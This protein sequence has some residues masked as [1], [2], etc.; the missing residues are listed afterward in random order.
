MC[1]FVSLIYFIL[2]NIFIFQCQFSVIHK[3]C[4]L[5]FILTLHFTEECMPKE[6]LPNALW[7]VLAK[8]VFNL[9]YPWALGVAQQLKYVKNIFNLNLSCLLKGGHKITF[10]VRWNRQLKLINVHIQKEE[11]DEF[12]KKVAKVADRGDFDA[13][14]TKIW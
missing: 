6:T 2:K 13:A 9:P 7:L 10:P 8:A 14:E 3:T 11:G 1:T 12:Y 5:R 4:F